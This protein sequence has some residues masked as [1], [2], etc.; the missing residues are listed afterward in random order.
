MHQNIWKD[1]ISRKRTVIL[2]FWNGREKKKTLY[3]VQTKD[4][5]RAKLVCDNL[6]TEG[7]EKDPKEL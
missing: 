2:S 1:V 5:K 7:K 6:Y 3:P 4:R